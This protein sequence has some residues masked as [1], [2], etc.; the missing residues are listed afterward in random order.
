MRTLSA[1]AAAASAVIAIAMAASPAHAHAALRH[2]DPAAG[3]SLDAPPKQLSLEFSTGVNLADAEIRLET[4]SGTQVRLDVPKSEPAQGTIL[5]R[6]IAAPL[7]DG[8]Y[9]VFWRVLSVD[10][11]YTRGDYTFEIRP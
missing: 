3:Q 10:G 8:T 7:A 9:H 11:H 1:R 5:R 4:P 6:D 2:A